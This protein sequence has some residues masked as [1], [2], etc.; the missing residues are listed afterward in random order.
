MPKST[1]APNVVAS[2]LDTST[3]GHLRDQL[4]FSVARCLAPF[5]VAPTCTCSA[6]SRLASTLGSDVVFQT[7]PFLELI[8]KKGQIGQNLLCV[9]HIIRILLENKVDFM[10]RKDIALG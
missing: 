7:S 10:E 5:K 8:A 4:T 3:P 9:M 6:P 1:S 2:I